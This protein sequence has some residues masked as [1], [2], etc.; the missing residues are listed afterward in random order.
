MFFPTR[1]KK[2]TPLSAHLQDIHEPV[3]SIIIDY[4]S[5]SN[6]KTQGKALEMCVCNINSRINFKR[7]KKDLYLVHLTE[8][9]NPDSEQQP[10]Q[11]LNVQ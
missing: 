6:N 10:V 5:N 1:K 3:F 7:R 11:V 4:S 9:C 2:K 8:D